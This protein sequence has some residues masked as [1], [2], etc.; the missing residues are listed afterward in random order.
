MKEVSQKFFVFELRCVILKASYADKLRF[1]SFALRFWACEFHFYRKSRRKALFLSLSCIVAGNVRRKVPLEAFWDQF[2]SKAI[3]SQIKWNWNDWIS[4]QLNLKSIKSE[5]LKT[6]GIWGHLVLNHLTVKQLNWVIVARCW[7]FWAYVGAILGCCGG[8]LRYIYS[9]CW[10]EGL[11]LAK[12]IGFGWFFRAITEKI[13]L[14][15]SIVYVEERGFPIN[16]VIGFVFSPTAKLAMGSLAQSSSGAIRCS[17]NTRFRR[18]FWRVPVQMADGVPGGSGADGWWS[19]EVSTEWTYIWAGQ[20]VTPKKTDV[21]YVLFAAVYCCS[22]HCRWFIGWCCC[23]NWSRAGIISLT[24][25]WAPECNLP[26]TLCG[27]RENCAASN[28][29][30]NTFDRPRLHVRA[31]L[32]Q[33]SAYVGPWATSGDLEAMLEAYV[34][35]KLQSRNYSNF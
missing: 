11:P 2:R 22:C 15:V 30:P 3:E 24:M 26:S 12:A 32:D 1:L 7:P 35:N 4:H 23:S 20:P 5:Y 21:C 33:Y 8:Q 34:D 14:E 10:R 27:W 18:R 13:T 28:L 9:W 16:K 17:C 31:M 25:C 6:N 29:N 19:S